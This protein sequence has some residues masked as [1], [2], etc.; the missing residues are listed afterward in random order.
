MLAGEAADAHPLGLFLVPVV[1][2]AQLWSLATGRTPCTHVVSDEALALE[3]ADQL[4]DHTGVRKAVRVIAGNENVDVARVG[5]ATTVA[6]HNLNPE[7]V[8]NRLGGHLDGFEYLPALVTRDTLNEVVVEIKTDLLVS[9]GAHNA[10]TF[11]PA[12]RPNSLVRRSWIERAPFA[13]RSCA[14]FWPIP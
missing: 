4:F 13:H 2:G 11:W 10:L 3:V 5:L 7:L 9:S 1:R 8:V 6:A 14:S 12:V